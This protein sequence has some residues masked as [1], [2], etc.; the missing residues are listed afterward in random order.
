MCFYREHAH[1]AFTHAPLQGV[2]DVGTQP[3]LVS[4]RRW[5][6]RVAGGCWGVG[7]PSP[8]GLHVKAFVWYYIR[9]GVLVESR[10]L[11]T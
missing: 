10:Y 6:V 4:A 11:S 5:V 2:E 9:I 8:Q 7:F 3:W 1:P